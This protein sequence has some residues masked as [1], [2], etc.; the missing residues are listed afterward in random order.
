L[1]IFSVM[2]TILF[3]IS[4]ALWCCFETFNVNIVLN[5]FCCIQVTVVWGKHVTCLAQSHVF[6]KL[7]CWDKAF[8]H[9]FSQLVLFSF[10]TNER[11]FEFLQTLHVIT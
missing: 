1:L 4:S 11:H 9:V 10:F 7:I 2:C 8:P 6:S 5:K 3:S